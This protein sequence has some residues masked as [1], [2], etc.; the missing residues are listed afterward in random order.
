MYTDDSILVWTDQN[1]INEIIKDVKKANLDIKVEGDIQDFLVINIE[2]NRYGAITLSQPHLI[3]DI[4]KYIRLDDE[5]K[6]TK[7]I[8]ALRSR[9]LTGHKYLE[10]FDRLFYYISVIGR[11]NYLEK[12]S[13]SDLSYIVY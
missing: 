5:N 2:W 7:Q 9:L 13:R 11:L 1:E 10:E 3:D 4:L 8:P 6:V 12:C